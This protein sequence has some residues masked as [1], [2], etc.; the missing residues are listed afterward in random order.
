MIA[1]SSVRR[2]AL[3]VQVKRAPK[4]PRA[5]A[6]IGWICAGPRF[7]LKP[8]VPSGFTSSSVVVGVSNAVDQL[9][10]GV[11]ASDTTYDTPMCPVDAVIAREPPSL[12]W[13]LLTR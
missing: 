10:Y 9:A 12:T 5:P 4:F 13:L 11:N 3:S 6:S 2:N 7:W 1:L 8:P